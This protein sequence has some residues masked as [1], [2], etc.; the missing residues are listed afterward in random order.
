MSRYDENKRAGMRRM[1]KRWGAAA[2][3]C[4]SKQEEIDDYKALIDS[5]YG[6]GA[7]KITGMPHGSGVSDP[8]LNTAE[9][10]QKLKAQYEKRIENIQA[11]IT[12]LLDECAKID[13]ELAGL[14]DKQQ[15]VVNLRYRRFGS[16]RRQPWARTAH[17]MDVS[18]VYA[19][20][21]EKQ[22]VDELLKKISPIF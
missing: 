7:S 4:K 3:I 19:K 21:L 1:L 11:D 6:A 13:K 10:A 8:T 5:L 12:D 20:V 2:R 22:A 18:E 9:R 14:T 16:A 15:E 17:L